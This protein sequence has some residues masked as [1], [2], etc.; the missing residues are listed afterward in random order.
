MVGEGWPRQAGRQEEW[1]GPK[2][3]KKQAA[4]GNLQAA[5]L[6]GVNRS[7]KVVQCVGRLKVSV[8]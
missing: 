7:W 5:R 3:T 4:D 6:Q 8:T 2:D 1:V